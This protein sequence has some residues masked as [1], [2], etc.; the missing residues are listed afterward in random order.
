MDEAAKVRLR[1]LRDDSRSLLDTFADRL[2]ERQLAWSRRF[3]FVG[4]WTE[5]V[6]GLCAYLVKGEI[7]VTPAERDAIAAVLVQFVDPRPA[8]KYLN[9]PDGTL[10]AL[11][12]VNATP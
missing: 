12:I 6:D 2:T 11:T 8:Y 5:L 3:D 1:R 10:A 7:P 9:D 4:E